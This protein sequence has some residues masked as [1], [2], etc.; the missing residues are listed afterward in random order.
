MHGFYYSL[1]FRIGNNSI[2]IVVK[3]GE[4]VSPK[5]RANGGFRPQS[6]SVEFVANC[7]DKSSAFSAEEV[8]MEILELPV[9]SAGIVDLSLFM[10]LL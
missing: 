9:L 2:V 5:R 8:A 6:S 7:V 4:T 1:Q 10:T 3:G